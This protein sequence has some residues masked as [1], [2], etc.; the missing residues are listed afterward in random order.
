MIAELGSVS[1][2]VFFANFARLPLRTLRLKSLIY[3]EKFK[4]YYRKERRELP[5]SSQKKTQTET[6]P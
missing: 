6:L 3:L 4:S 2:W 5:Q 1:V